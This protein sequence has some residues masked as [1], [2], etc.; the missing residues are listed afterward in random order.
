MQSIQVL[1][2]CVISPDEIH[3][4]SNLSSALIKVLCSPN[5]YKQAKCFEVKC[6]Q[7]LSTQVYP[8]MNCI[9]GSYKAV[10]IYEVIPYHIYLLLLLKAFALQMFI[11]REMF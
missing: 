11:K 6:S 2:Q 9:I 8:N 4:V 1:T 7:I 5:V 3:T 10:K